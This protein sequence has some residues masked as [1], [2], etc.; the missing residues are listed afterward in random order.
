MSK[1]LILYIIYKIENQINYIEATNGESGYTI[2][3]HE[4]IEDLKEVVNKE[5]TK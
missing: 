4:F 3:A 5:P 1:E 2:T